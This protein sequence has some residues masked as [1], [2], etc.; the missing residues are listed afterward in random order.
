MTTIAAPEPVLD[1]TVE[2]EI[3][4]QVSLDFM[5]TDYQGG[6]AGHGGWASMIFTIEGGSHQVDIVEDGVNLFTREN[7]S[8][9][10]K[11]IVTACGDWELEGFA[12]NLVALADKLRPLV[13]ARKRKR[14]EF[15]RRLRE[16]PSKA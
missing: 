13:E 8:G 16:A 7:D 4:E 9:L 12:E 15:R 1:E 11:V 6:D 10:L 2:G 5:T 3:P 14:E